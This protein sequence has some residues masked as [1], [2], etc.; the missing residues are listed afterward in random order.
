MKNKFF[1]ILISMLLVACLAVTMVA[2]DYDDD[3][4]DAE[5]RAEALNKFVSQIVV[6]SNNAWSYNMPQDSVAQMKDAGDYYVLNSWATFIAEVVDNSGLQTAKIETIT[7]FLASENGKELLAGDE[8]QILDFL[9]SAGLTSTDAENIVYTALVLFLEKGDQIYT[10]AI[11]NIEALPYEKLSSETSLNVKEAK[12]SLVAGKQM[13]SDTV[14]DRENAV[15]ALKNAENGV[16]TIVSYTFNISTYFNNDTNK[17]LIDKISSGT[18]TGA[19]TGE[20]ATYI[21]AVLDSIEEAGESIEGKE[22]E[23][24]DALQKV[25]A[26]YDKLIVDNETMDGIFSFVA[27]NKN[28]PSTIPALVEMA[29]NAEGVALKN[30]G[31]E[32]PFVEGVMTLL[33]DG[34]TYGDDRTSANEYIAYARMGLALVGIDY[35]ATGDVLSR[36]IAEARTFAEGT[37]HSLIDNE[38][39]GSK[40][41]IVK[42]A[43]LL[44]LDSEEGT[45]IGNVEATRV[46]KIWLADLVYDLFKKQYRE[47]SLGIVDHTWNLSE[48]ARTLMRFVTG[49]TIDVGNNFTAQWYEE[50]C[51]NVDATFES[52]IEVCYPAVKADIDNRVDALFDTAIDELVQ[53]ALMEP[54]KVND[55]SYLSFEDDFRKLYVIVMTTLLPWKMQ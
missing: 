29:E 30:Q 40:K 44:Y 36:Q 4:A 51:R 17:G 52:E 18:L 25:V 46:C 48:N 55:D 21:G 53:M 39:L 13:F 34:Y 35:T 31:A 41:E 54:V 10:T 50:I 20:I 19:T 12:A 1:T 27:D 32:Y 22:Q 6:S 37:T 16:K 28:L 45:M 15:S 14:V 43:G 47:H 11:N 2:C 7:A 5:K 23:I 3:Q 9:H 33:G 24:C 42:I 26:V 49:E 38:S 8:V